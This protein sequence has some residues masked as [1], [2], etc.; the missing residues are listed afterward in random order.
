MVL[1]DPSSLEDAVTDLAAAMESVTLGSPS[2]SPS[3]SSSVVRALSVPVSCIGAIRCF[4][5]SV[6]VVS[7]L[8]RLPVHRLA[9]L[10]FLCG[11]DYSKEIAATCAMMRGWE[12]RYTQQGQMRLAAG[13]SLDS[14]VRAFADRAQAVDPTIQH[15]HGALH[16]RLSAWIAYL[17]HVDAVFGPSVPLRVLRVPIAVHRQLVADAEAL[18]RFAEASALD[19]PAWSSPVVLTRK[20][21]RRAWFRASCVRRALAKKAAKTGWLPA[22]PVV[23]GSLSRLRVHCGLAHVASAGQLG[24]GR[25][26]LCRSSLPGPR[27]VGSER[28][29]ICV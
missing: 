16:Q 9:E 15:A 22:R 14:I 20:Q 23:C 10:S 2:P 8:L 21:K 11:N 18:T 12:W 25:A 4:P 17:Q 5:L 13:Q 6:S 28:S 27:A 3:P 19:G 7:H 29:A 24:H 1:P 26:V